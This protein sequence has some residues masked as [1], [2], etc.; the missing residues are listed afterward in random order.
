[1]DIFNFSPELT[2][3]FLLTFIRISII[4]FMLPI[5]DVQSVPTSWKGAMCLIL[6]LAFFPVIGL[7]SVQM[8]AHPF[9]IFLMVMGEV[10]LGL[11]LGLSVQFFFMGIQTGGE[12]LAMQMGFTM[13]TLADP[14]SGNNTGLVAHFL[15]MVATLTFLALDGHLYLFKAFVDTFQIVPAG[16]LV[17][18]G[19]LMNEVLNLSAMVL[20][21]GIRIA[22]PIMSVLFLIEVSLGML[23]RVAP[24]IH[25]MEL[26]FPLKIAVGFFF[27]G[28]LFVIISN[29]SA[30]FITGLD[31]MFYNLLKAMAPLP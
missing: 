1:M 14:V 22:A 24:Q 3:G 17:I 7:P 28:M 31:G 5:F 13:I 6:T 25:I 20:V 26:G 21:F 9:G 8:P 29:E 12:S 2:L 16:G 4:L 18:R 19:V 15:Y 23:T 10:I 11:V 30:N 27:I